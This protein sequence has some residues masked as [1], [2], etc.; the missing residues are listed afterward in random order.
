MSYDG[1]L[2]PIT[3]GT[4]P[5]MNDGIQLDATCSYVASSV[6]D[7]DLPPAY[8]ALTGEMVESSRYV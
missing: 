8:D 5:L 3:I 4:I 6:N 1:I 7:K 2:I